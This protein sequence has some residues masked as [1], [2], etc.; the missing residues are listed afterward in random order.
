MVPRFVVHVVLLYMCHVRPTF[1]QLEV[2]LKAPVVGDAVVEV[3]VDHSVGDGDISGEQLV[4]VSS[5]L[6]GGYFPTNRRSKV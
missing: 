5:K 3:L 6:M 1:P 4:Q 2:C